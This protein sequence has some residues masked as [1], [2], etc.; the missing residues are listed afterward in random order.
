MGK[1]DLLALLSSILIAVCIISGSVLGGDLYNPEVEDDTGETDDP[2][3]AFRDIESAW[4]GGETNSTMEVSLKLVG[5]PP[6]L[7]D[8]ANAQDTTIFEYEVYFDVEGVGY[9]VVCSVQYATS[10]GAGTPIGGV[11]SPTQTWSTELR[12]VTYAPFTDVILSETSIGDAVSFEYNS[13][14]V[15]F[16]WTL[17]KNDIGVENGFEGRGQKL[18][19]TWAAVWNAEDASSGGQRNPES[20]SWDYAQTHYS[21][22]GKEYRIIGEGN[23]DYN[24]ELSVGENAK[25]TYGGTP[26][27]FLVSVRNNGSQE[28]TVELFATFSD[29]AWNVSID[30]KVSTVP[31]GST[32]NVEVAVTPPKEVDNGTTLIVVI[33]GAIDL[34]DG[35]GTVPI[36]STVYLYTT[37]L[38]TSEEDDN[39]LWDILMDNIMYMFAVIG[40]IIFIIIIIILLVIRRK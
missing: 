25:I 9:A 23:V 16:K 18:V 3:M 32:R 34:V 26:A 5:E 6:G 11:Y 1:R 22:P 21:D 15:V 8:L 28:F 4:F 36:Q 20:D 35:N 7:M 24:V 37:G 2:T 29:E 19:N 12:R 40:A 39:S 13:D 10:I 14:D 33:T 31:Q 17:L 38:A 27:E 30:P